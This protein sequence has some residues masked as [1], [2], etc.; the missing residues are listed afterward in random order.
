MTFQTV[1]KQDMIPFK[2]Q[3]FSKKTNH[4]PEYFYSVT[5]RN[6]NILVLR[7]FHCCSRSR[8][9]RLHPVT[10]G[11]PLRWAPRSRPSGDGRWWRASRPQRSRPTVKQTNQRKWQH[12]QIR[13]IIIIINYGWNGDRLLL[14][15]H[16]PITLASDWPWHMYLQCPDRIEL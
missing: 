7:V 5:K 8:K 6:N 3:N 10:A 12:A 11:Q 9:L 4:L 2:G 16:L 14:F 15:G 13:N 1:F